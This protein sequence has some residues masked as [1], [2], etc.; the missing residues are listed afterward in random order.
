MANTILRYG[1]IKEET[2]FDVQ[3]PATGGVFIDINSV[4]LDVPSE[5]D[6]I[7]PSSFGRAPRRK[8]AGFY[9][10]SGNIAYAMDVRTIAFFMKWALGGYAFTAG[11]APGPPAT[12]NT[13]ESWGSADRILK[14][15]VA[16]IGKDEFEHVFT[17]C[18]IDTIELE[19]EDEFVTCT[20]EIISARDARA[21]QQAMATVFAA[22]PAESPLTS[23]DA[24]VR[25]GGT[26]ESAR[27]KSL[28]F[29][30]ANNAD[31]EAGRGMGS[32]FARRVPVNERETTFSAELDFESMAQIERI[33]GGPNGPASSGAAEFP[34]EI[35]L[36]GGSDGDCVIR[37]PRAHYTAVETQPEGREE[38][39]Q[40]VEGRAMTENVTLGDTT[41]T[42]ST[43][44]YVKSRN[45][46][47]AI[48]SA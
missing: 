13:H 42:V 24:T 33:W 16:R 37:L 23:Q 30:L 4:S 8:R 5:T 47:P 38:A 36:N 2:A 9:Q 6:L 44:V 19:V 14:S 31:G 48:S 45:N 22:L 12:K 18:V 21:T 3:P 28:T 35:T 39:V 43:D 15:F 20:A 26:D 41:T 32:R 11:A 27:V 46:A 17:G 10:P 29:S 25:I 7:V 40:S 34:F 1:Q